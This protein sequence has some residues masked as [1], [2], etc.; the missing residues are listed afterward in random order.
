MQ[1]MYKVYLEEGFEEVCIQFKYNKSQ[2]NLVQRFRR[3]LPEYKGYQ[4][5]KSNKKFS[6]KL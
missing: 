6:E 1:Y 4:R 2:Q 3:Y 5:N